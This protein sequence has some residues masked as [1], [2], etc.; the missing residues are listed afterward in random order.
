MDINTNLSSMV[1]SQIQVNNMATN[2]SDIATS[3]GDTEFQE[4]SQD[5]ID[6]IIGQ[7]P[8]VLTYQANAKSI[9]TQNEISD[10]LLNIKA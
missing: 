6:S 3:V 1:S 7:I 8:Q 10:M 5:L 9:E 4:V 2:L